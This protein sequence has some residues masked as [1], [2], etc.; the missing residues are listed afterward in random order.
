MVGL[1]PLSLGRRYRRHGTKNGNAL[2]L[3]ASQRAYRR[4]GGAEGAGSDVPNW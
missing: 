4:P 2:A 1:G 3:A